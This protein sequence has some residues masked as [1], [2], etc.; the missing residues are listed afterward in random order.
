LLD[1]SG[2]GGPGL[3]ETTGPA[4]ERLKLAYALEVP[5]AVASRFGWTSVGGAGVSRDGTTT[6][7]YE[8]EDS[9]QKRVEITVAPDATVKLN[10]LEG[11]QGSECEQVADAVTRA[12]G[13][14]TI[15]RTIKPE[16]QQ[17]SQS[18]QESVSQGAAE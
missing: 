2:P 18:E 4:G 5:P 7:L 10:F 9:M 13:G 3:E 12:L 16:Y 6:Y 15:E 14:T 17:V 8:S 1:F 11:F